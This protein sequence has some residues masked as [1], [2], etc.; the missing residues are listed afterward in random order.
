MIGAGAV[1][2]DAERPVGTGVDTRGGDG[3]RE[4]GVGD[5]DGEDGDG[6]VTLLTDRFWGNA[7]VTESRALHA[8]LVI[9]VLIG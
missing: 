3:D 5:A 8:S 1:R 2:A 9:I 4:L 6:D 7:A